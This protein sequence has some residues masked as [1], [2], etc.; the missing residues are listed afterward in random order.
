MAQPM[1]ILLVDDDE[2]VLEA[3]AWLLESQGHQVSLAASGDE[4]L[5]LLLEGLSVELLILDQ[6]MPGLSGV[7]TLSKVREFLPELPIFVATGY[8][9]EALAAMVQGHSR[10]LLIHKPFRVPEFQK[11]CE[12][13]KHLGEEG[14]AE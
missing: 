10:T 6:N 4:A 3:V 12:D 14:V 1:K 8:R 7:E 5:Q 11:A 13:L 9:D 2:L